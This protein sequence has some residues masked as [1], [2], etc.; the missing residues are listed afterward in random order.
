MKT[1]K[2]SYYALALV[3]YEK[4]TISGFLQPKKQK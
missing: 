3:Y 1:L 4:M 2:P